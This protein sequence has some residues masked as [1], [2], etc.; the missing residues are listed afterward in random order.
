MG[1]EEGFREIL[2]AQ[3]KDQY[4]ARAIDA[5]EEK[6]TPDRLKK[7]LEELEIKDGLTAQ[8]WRLKLAR[9]SLTV[10][11]T[12]LLERTR[13]PTLESPRSRP[14]PYKACRL[15]ILRGRHSLPDA[16]GILACH[17]SDRS[18]AAL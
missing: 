14:D 13:S 4:Q 6:I 18:I 5:A 1:L 3:R 2:R 16:E 7:R 8:R 11:P 12:D 9:P 10:I 15:A 17:L